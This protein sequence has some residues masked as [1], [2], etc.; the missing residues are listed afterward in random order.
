MQARTRLTLSNHE[1]L[2]E[3]SWGGYVVVPTYNLDVSIGA[4]RDGIIEPWTTETVMNN[5]FPGQRVIN[6]GA[7][8]GYYSALLGRLVGNL[9]TVFSIEA[10]P[11]LLSYLIKSIYYNG[12][13]N[14]TKIFSFA[15]WNA[16]E[17]IVLEF[18]PAFIGGGSVING[19]TQANTE[20]EKA[21]W[22]Q[23]NLSDLVS[24]P[25]CEWLQ[26]D[27]S[28]SVDVPTRPLDE[29][30]PAPIDFMLMDGEGSE[31]YVIL[32]MEKVLKDSPNFKF[33]SE[34]SPAYLNRGSDYRAKVRLMIELLGSLGFQAQHI[35][36]QGFPDWS[37]GPRFKPEELL[38]QANGDYLWTKS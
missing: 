20:I 6:V 17:N 26:N 8:F 23:S 35:N 31:P 9:G 18:N 37:L 36:P 2:V 33:I 24:M 4:I 25:N 11:Y 22:T 19:T 28:I 21:L 34:W 7:N 30:I 32:G 12:T 16:K 29:I 15:A 38:N 1:M 10:N 13:P 5:V 3:L 14:Q 27:R